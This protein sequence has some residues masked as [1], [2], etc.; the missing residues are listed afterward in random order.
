MAT[1]TGTTIASTYE[2]LIKLDT[3]TLGS[4]VSAKYLETG[5]AEDLPISVSTNRVG[6]GTAA[7]AESLE[8]VGEIKVQYLQLG[9]G[10][11][12]IENVVSGTHTGQIRINYHGYQGGDA[13]FRD[14]VIGNG[15]GGT[16]M[17][18]D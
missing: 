14:T 1:L 18:V 9:A 13:N 15:K 12:D 6:I 5:K 3:E 17:F 8:V 2:Q 11:T 16:I 4:G 10:N 7:P